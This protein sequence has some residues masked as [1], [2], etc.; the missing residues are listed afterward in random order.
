[1]TIEAQ[2]AVTIKAPAITIEADGV[3]Q[4]SGAQV[5]LG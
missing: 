1:V 2:A 3:V 5:M 4:I